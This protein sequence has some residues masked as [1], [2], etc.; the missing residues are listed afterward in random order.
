VTNAGPEDSRFGMWARVLEPGD[1]MEISV[2]P[3]FSASLADL[4]STLHLTYLDQGNGSIL[5]STG[6][7]EMTAQCEDSGEW[8]QTS[9]ELNGSVRQISIR[10]EGAPATLHMVEITRD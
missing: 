10:A 8:R 3:K 5:V 2:D 4:S 9:M 1:T 7:K 6:G